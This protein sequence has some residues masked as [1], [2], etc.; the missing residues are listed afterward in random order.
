MIYVVFALIA[1]VVVALVVAPL[2]RIGRG[3]TRSEDAI[4]VYRDQLAE[5]ERDVR[6]GLIDA[7]AAQAAR[8]EI[9]R[10]IL[11]EADAA[12]EDA[13]A[14]PRPR[15]TRA[16]ALVLIV[17]MPVAAAAIYARL[18]SPGLPDDPLASRTDIP[19]KAMTAEQK[20]KVD[21]LIAKLKSRLAADPSNTQGWLL[22]ANT[23]GYLGRF[24]EASQAM[25]KALALDSSVAAWHSAYGEF[26][27]LAHD[28]MVTPTAHRAFQDAL[29]IDPKDPVG[30]Y[31]MG[32]AAAQAG[33]LKNALDIWRALLADTPSD[34]TWLKP[35]KAHI[36]EA[37]KELNAMPSG[38]AG[39]ASGP[40]QQDVQAAQGMS[41][42]DQ[43]AM[44][45]TMVQRLADHLKSNPNDLEGWKKLG[46]SYAVLGQ[47][48]DA[49]DA[50]QHALKLSPDDPQLLDG[51]ARSVAN[52]LDRSKPI[53]AD[54][55]AVF[56][57]VLKKAPDNDVAL[58]MTGLAAAQA[59]DKAKAKER[60]TRLRDLFPKGSSE[61]AK[62]ESLLAGVQ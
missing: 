48:S 42:S 22:L 1:L 6:R 60:W 52:G 46:H 47:W 41:Q 44:I 53:P 15:R 20:T 26:V 58:Y 5:V 9:E 18:G 33:D 56:E 8:R 34:A 39:Q 51:L 45:K 28:G 54:A 36:A 24:A 40:T 59:G 19:S 38:S 30:R 57:R 7:D 16:I 50:Y 35:L 31:Y 62:I 17:A 29:A 61:R 23:D 10:R 25:A 13:A 43:L 21:E 2:L 27:A 55:V 11:A 49:R 3:M 37:Q 12:S 14:P 4:A 32:M